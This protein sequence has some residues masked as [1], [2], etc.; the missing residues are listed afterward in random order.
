VSINTELLT[1]ED[2]QKHFSEHPTL[3]H[4]FDKK[5]LITFDQLIEGLKINYPELKVK[6]AEIEQYIKY[7]YLPKLYMEN[8]KI[9][10]LIH[11]TSRIDFIKKI[12]KKWKY[13]SEEIKQII[14]YEDMLIDD[15]LT[16][17]E[18]DYSSLPSLPFFIKYLKQTI[19]ENKIILKYEEKFSVKEELKRRNK[20]YDK[21]L[22]SLEGKDFNKLPLSTQVSINDAV[23]EINFNLEALRIMMVMDLRAKML[24][25]FSP[26]IHTLRT[27][28]TELDDDHEEK[29]E[30][31]Y[32]IVF[33]DRKWSY[34]KWT[35]NPNQ[36]LHEDKFLATPEFYIGLGYDNTIN[37]SIRDPGRVN[38]RF[39]RRIE[40]YYTKFRENL[41]IPK[42]QWG[43]ISGRKKLL[44]ERNKYLRTRYKELRGD[45][46]YAAAEKQ[47][48]KV[49]EEI[50]TKF[51]EISHAR[52]ERI[53]Y[54]K[55]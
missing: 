6:P 35:C 49:L 36:I 22:K 27:K 42:K 37:I 21:I 55:K 20:R 25:G 19:K 39:M 8:G 43:E 30:Y 31:P 10:F 46:P 11:S 50:K 14:D 34:G 28:W 38:A 52:A 32:S 15:V 29:D 26:H 9:G 18:L 51:G 41:N 24:L 12:I 16:S 3:F 13:N 53:I 23:F 1:F 47:L 17:E 45:K 54:K 5:F 40:K 4:L 44:A 2:F 48:D 33:F 7:G